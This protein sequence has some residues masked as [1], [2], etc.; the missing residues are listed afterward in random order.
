MM[1][2]LSSKVVLPGFSR[3]SR[4]PFSFVAGSPDAR[5]SHS[6]SSSNLRQ[7][8][9]Q[10]AQEDDHNVIAND[11][12]LRPQPHR[13]SL[14]LGLVCYDPLVPSIWRGMMRHFSRCGLDVDFVTFT[15]YER[16]LEALSRRLITIAWN[17][18]LAHSRCIRV[19][20]GDVISLG[21]RDVDRGFQAHIVTREDANI[22]KAADINGKRV[23]AGTVDSPQAYIMPLRALQESNEVDL[24]SL[25]VTRFDRDI[26][27]HGDT[28]IG[29]DAVLAALSSGDVEVGFLSELMWERYRKAGKT[30][31]LRI[32]DSL[33]V[34]PFD[35]CQFTALRQNRSILSVFAEALLLMER[36]SEIAHPENKVTMQLE[37]IKQKWMP[38][39]SHLRPEVG[40]EAMLRAL[41]EWQEPRLVW[42]GVLHTSDK[43]PFRA[44]K[45]DHR[46]VRDA[47]GC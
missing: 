36:E 6:S 17:G 32:L 2:S 42:P 21:M 4:L 3:F 33:P 44:L 14:L 1:L 26:G 38:P 13:D 35:H 15:S 43:H 41:D 40:Y 37:G 24:K 9:L 19:F 7:R 46:L 11:H 25:A 8:L 18:P 34:K 10:A 23:A 47:N 22:H 28:A 29:E 20:D 31:G 16:L 5:R 39:R 45:I 30:R 27:K 12:D